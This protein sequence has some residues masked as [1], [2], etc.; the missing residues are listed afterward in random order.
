M[1][2]KPGKPSARIELLD[3]S[4]GRR[5]VFA[6]LQ[7]K[8][9]RSLD[10]AGAGRGFLV[11]F[12]GI[13]DLH[14]WQIGLLSYPDGE[15]REITNDTNS[16]LFQNSSSNGR[17]LAAIVRTGPV[18]RLFL[19]PSTG[20]E[21]P[22]PP[23]VPLP[24]GNL[25]TFSWDTDGT[26]LLAGDGKLVRTNTRGKQETSLLRTPGTMVARAPVP[27]NAGR[28]LVFEWDHPH[29]EKNVNV[30]RMDPDGSNLVQ[31]TTGGD[32]ED[33]VCP[34]RGKWV[35]YVDATKPQPMRINIDGGRAEPVPGSTVPGGLYA[36]GNIALSP[37]GQR[38]LYLAKVQVPGASTLEYR[39][40]IV[41]L[42][43][44][45]KQGPELVEVDQRIQY[46]PQFTPD[47]SAIAYSIT[48][49]GAP[50]LWLQPLN[51]Q[52]KRRITN[53]SSDSYTRVF[54]WSPDGKTL[55][56][57]RSRYDSDVVLL[58]DSN[59]SQ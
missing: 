4:S 38:L 52:P 49:N 25:R 34:G 45:G 33:P 1:S 36:W 26:L 17:S 53:F 16:Y 14:H 11:D 51:G 59:S 13:G 54:Y 10:W 20:T 41:N 42:A 21:D 29:G 12:A 8:F 46:P 58:T 35:Y 39:A 47:G 18:G 3:V 15:F 37:D 57:I 56:T 55:G 32:G 7:N 31:L 2:A 40:V 24:I 23:S 9:I 48:V 43:A 19:L 28:Y 22:S 50:N 6:S 44:D 27:C 30:W 5:Q